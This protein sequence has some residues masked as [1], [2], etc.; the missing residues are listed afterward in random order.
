MALLHSPLP[1]SSRKRKPRSEDDTPALVEQLE[2]QLITAISSKSSLNKLSDLLNIALNAQDVAHLSKSVYALYRVFVSVISNGMLLSRNPDEAAEAVHAWLMDKLNVYVELL[3]GL[4]KDEE[5]VL[6]TSAL[7][8]LLSLQKHLSTSLSAS[9]SS[10]QEQPQF[11]LSHFRKIVTALLF[12]PPSQRSSPTAKKQKFENESQDNASIEPDVKELF[13]RKWLDVYDDIRWFFLRESGNIVARH[14]S[15]KG[16]SAAVN[17]LSILEG[18]TTCPTEASELN[19]WWVEEFGTRPRASKSTGSDEDEADEDE[20]V[21]DLKDDWRAFFDQEPAKLNSTKSKGSSAR[22]HTLT[23]HESLHSLASHRAVFTHAW[24]ALLP[25]LSARPSDSKALSLRVLNVLHRGVIPHLTRP[26][27]I[28]DWV[29]GVVGLLALN[30]LFVLMKEYNLDYPSF[31][32][33]LYAFLDRDVLHLK[34]RARFFRLTELFLSSTHLPA[35]L[36]AS[37]VK[38]LSRLSLNAPPAAVVMI[39]PLVYNLFRRHPALMPMIHRTDYD[40]TKDT[41]QMDEANPALTNALD[42]SLWE[43]YSHRQHY[44]AV[45]ST[46]ACIFEEAFTRPA[47][48]VEDF[49]DHAYGTMYEAEARRRIQKGPAANMDWQFGKDNSTAVALWG[50]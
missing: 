44:H 12:C 25:A 21:A 2:N 19:T 20:P 37:F 1:S 16:G 4:L 35:A 41:F 5:P 40:T 39:I 10:S 9:S 49:L 34:H 45:V 50:L 46:M 3:T 17:L 26:I 33:R 47:Y 36:V 23:L 43:L 22:L 14:P 11:Y 32:T 42:S 38:R 15:E 24:L 6:R 8:V 7:Q 31:Y 29:R 13:V 18:L 48:S 28:M 27:L 30:A